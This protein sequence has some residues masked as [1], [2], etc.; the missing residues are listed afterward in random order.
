MIHNEQIR[1]K[2]SELDGTASLLGA[3]RKAVG[4]QAL[5]WY[6][7]QAGDDEIVVEAALLRGRDLPRPA[8]RTGPGYYSGKSAVLNVVPTGVGC[9]L[10]G[11]AGDAAPVTN[12]LAATADFL[13][14]N[15][16]AVNASNFV[17]LDS[18]NIVYTDGCTMDL[19][20]QG[21]ADLHLPYAN[22]IGLIVEKTEGWH[23][24]KVYNIVNAVRAI[25]G[26]DIAEVLVTDGPIG[27]RCMENQSGAFVGTIDH[28]GVLLE[29]C[30]K[31][32]RNGVSA[33]AITSN[34]QDL[35]S[36]NYARH[37]DGQY[38]NPV[39]GVEA[40]ISYMVTTH[41]GVPSAHAPMIN[42]KQLDLRD[43]VVDARG[44]GEMAST[45]G[46]ACVLIGLHRAPVLNP[47]KGCRI[48]EVVNT[49]NLVAVVMPAGCLGGIPAICADEQ[50]IPLIAVRDN[51][52][53]L[54]VTSGGLGLGN[55]IEVGSY[56][57]A[58]G[59]VMAL[60]KGISVES[61]YRPLQ[62]LRRQEVAEPYALAAAT[63]PGDDQPFA[64][65]L[66]T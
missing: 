34:I 17:G 46:L 28:P 45:S 10:G 61:L 36:E 1:I 21:L 37:F 60:R 8:G 33:V 53:I 51:C 41:F 52:T 26:V 63:A 20:S 58:A 64:E 35:P 24:D 15:P 39:G 54:N 56:A 31:L 23:L 4:G 19:F 49:N 6:V 5:R 66:S 38:P 48:S 62:T 40:I 59:V 44:A 42:I 47:G 30:E 25:H 12:L 65:L 13:I 3:V 7:S 55:V 2:R 9:S 14:T 29:A 57:E 32:V 18:R 11:Y 16:N 22:R 43:E 27:G 50:G